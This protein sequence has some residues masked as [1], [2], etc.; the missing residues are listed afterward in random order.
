M[1]EQSFRTRQRLRAHFAS[2]E[3]ASLLPP[4][5]DETDVR[6][7]RGGVVYLALVMA[8]LFGMGACA[9]LASLRGMG[10]R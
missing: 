10:G 6:V 5:R 1:G 9:L 8:C 3:P 7:T 2:H 4:L